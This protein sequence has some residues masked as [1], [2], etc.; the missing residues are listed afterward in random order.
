MLNAQC[1]NDTKSVANNYSN[2]LGFVIWKGFYENLRRAKFK[3]SD[4][5]NAD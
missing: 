1:F 2:A 4:I 5:E 3:L